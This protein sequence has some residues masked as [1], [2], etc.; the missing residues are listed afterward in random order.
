MECAKTHID[1]F[2]LLSIA[3]MFVF[4]GFIVGMVVAKNIFTSKE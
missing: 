3:V 1:I 2:S 4:L